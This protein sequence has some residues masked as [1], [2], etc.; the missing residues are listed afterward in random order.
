M[1]GAASDF[2]SL[3]F[4]LAP[5]LGTCHAPSPTSSSQA[6]PSGSC[7]W[8]VWSQS[9]G[10]SSAGYYYVCYVDY[11]GLRRRG[12]LWIASLRITVDCV[13]DSSIRFYYSCAVGQLDIT[14]SAIIVDSCGLRRR[15]LPW[16]YYFRSSPLHHLVVIMIECSRV[17][18]CGFSSS[19]HLSFLLVFIAYTL[20]WY[21]LSG[22]L[23]SFFTSLY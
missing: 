13:V 6:E 22:V 10:G 20:S 7:A 2:L 16:I 15:G 17:Q 9:M 3:D 19:S 21:V 1:L 12:L 14:M 11:C 8:L 5:D 18:V 4:N 23:I